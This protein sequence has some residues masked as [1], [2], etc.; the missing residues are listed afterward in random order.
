MPIGYKQQAY[1]YDIDNELWFAACVAPQ[2]LLFRIGL[3]G[4]GIT[5]TAG[6]RLSLD[7]EEETRSR[8]KH[9]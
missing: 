7:G 4:L 3:I 5:G 9:G 1:S 2:H 6:R 8:M